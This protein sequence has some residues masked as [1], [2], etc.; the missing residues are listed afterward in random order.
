MSFSL[1]HSR[2]PS[3][4]SLFLVLFCFCFLQV[5]LAMSRPE[6]INPP[7]VRVLFV[8]VLRVKVEGFG[9]GLSKGGNRCGEDEKK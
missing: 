1:T 4:N 2:A 8:A 7:E 9:G 6:H 3:L 5:G